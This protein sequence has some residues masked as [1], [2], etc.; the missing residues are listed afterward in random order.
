VAKPCIYAH[1]FNRAAPRP[2][3]PLPRPQ[4]LLFVPPLSRPGGQVLFP[5][6]T[7]FWLPSPVVVVVVVVVVVTARWCLPCQPREVAQTTP[8]TTSWTTHWSTHRLLDVRSWCKAITTPPNPRCVFVLLLARRRRRRLGWWKVYN[9][10]R[11]YRNWVSVAFS[12]ISQR[13]VTTWQRRSD[14][15]H[16]AL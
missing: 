4:L 13:R 12:C 3:L 10:I 15:F 9:F 16:A 5:V 11:P 14:S 2:Q 1:C 8:W 6:S 7:K